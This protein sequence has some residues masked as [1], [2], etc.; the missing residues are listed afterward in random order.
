[1]LALRRFFVRLNVF[2]TVFLVNVL[3]KKQ[4]LRSII[5]WDT[6]LLDPESAQQVVQLSHHSFISI[7]Y[8]R[9]GQIKSK[10]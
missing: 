9:I 7:S 2:K 5:D 4:A 6:R 1:M 3:Q 8:F 10:H